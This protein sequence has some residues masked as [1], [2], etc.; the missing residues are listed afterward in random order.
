VPDYE[1]PA[2]SQQV[3]RVVMS[4]TDYVNRTVWRKS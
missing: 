2:V 3:L 4:Y 1:A